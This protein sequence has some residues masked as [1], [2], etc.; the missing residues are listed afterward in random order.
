[1]RSLSVKL[2]RYVCGGGDRKTNKKRSVPVLA[3]PIYK[4]IEWI[5]GILENMMKYVC[6]SMSSQKEK[7]KTD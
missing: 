2:N 5:A 3:A 4:Y 7:E 1:M 6:I